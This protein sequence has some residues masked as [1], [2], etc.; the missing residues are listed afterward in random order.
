MNEGPEVRWVNIIDLGYLKV[1]VKDLDIKGTVGT[2][3]R[4]SDDRL[5]RKFKCQ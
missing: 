5:V 4:S 3:N 2:D 1:K